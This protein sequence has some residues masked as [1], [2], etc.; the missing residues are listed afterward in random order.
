MP[1]GRSKATLQP[2]TLLL[3]PLVI[4]Y[5]PSHP[6]PQSETLA[7]EAVGPAAYAGFASQ[8]APSATVRTV[9]R[10]RELGRFMGAST[11]GQAAAGSYVVTPSYY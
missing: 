6:V 2:V 4:V 5:L 8:A 7:K 1:A 11:P 3:P 9:T 10:I